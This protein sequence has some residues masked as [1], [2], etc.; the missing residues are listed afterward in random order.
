MER[1]E[2]PP[3]EVAPGGAAEGSAEES[4]AEESSA[5][6]GSGRDGWLELAFEAGLQPGRV[7]GDGHM[8]YYERG[9]LKLVIPDQVVAIIHA[10]IQPALAAGEAAPREPRA[11]VKV[12]L[13]PGVALGTDGVVRAARA[14]AVRY[15]AGKLLDVVDQH[16]H[17]GAVDL[18]SGHLDMNGSLTVKGDVERLLQ[19]RASVDVE[20]V[21][22]VSGSV[23]AGAGLK[24]SGSVRGGDDAR[25]V[26]GGDATLGSCEVAEVSAG[27]TL[28]VREAVNSRLVAREVVVTGRLRGGSAVAEVSVV[29]KEAGTAAGTPTLLQAAEP[30]ALPDL[31]QLQRAVVMQKLRRM[32]ERGGVREAV[33]SRGDGRA[34]GGKLGRAVAALSA[35][36]LAERARAAQERRALQRAAFVQVDLAHPGVELQIGAARL[37]L[38]QSVRGARYA[39]DAETGQLRAERTNR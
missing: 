22:S 25:I 36:Q 7:V 3:S 10:A 37:V 20:V 12:T 24:V 38:E 16:V 19:V 39:W 18:R 31:Q 33:G 13:G 4:S 27:G 17:R 8:D 9:L 26:A 2:V 14:G 5:A 23:R 29:V 30:L 11:E 35:E 28:R 32:A 1:D 6:P 21:G 34:R 15:E